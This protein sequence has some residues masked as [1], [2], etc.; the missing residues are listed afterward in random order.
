M[1]SARAT[2]RSLT[3]RRLVGFSVESVAANVSRVLRGWGA[4]FRYGNSTRKFGVLDR[5]VHQ[6]MVIFASN[7][8]GLRGHRWRRFDEAWLRG[9]GVYRLTGTV[10]YGTAHAWR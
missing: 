10:R 6:R 4:Y 1:A 9:L 8:H 5:Y 3:D 2:I 7:K